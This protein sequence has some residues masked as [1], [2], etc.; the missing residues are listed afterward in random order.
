MPWRRVQ[1]ME[2]R[3]QFVMAAR[4][5]HFG[6]SQLC[7]EYGISRKTAYKWLGRYDGEHL[8]TLQDRSRAP[9]TCPHAMPEDV[10]AALVGARKA[11]R[12][13][14]PRKI[15]AYL[16]E[17]SDL[18]DRLP[19]ASTAGD[20]L[21][22]LGLVEPR[23]RRS[24]YPH[25][26][27]SPLEA[28]EPNDV[29]CVDFKGEFKTRD[30][31]WCYPLTVTDG[32]S[33]LLLM[34]DALPSTAHNGA[35]AAFQHLFAEVG[36]PL[37]IRSDNGCP[38]CSSA[39]NG[40]SRLSVWWTKLGIAHQR[41]RPASPHEN[42][43]HE[44]MHRTLKAETT[45]PPAQDARAQ[46]RRFDDFRYEFNEI[47][48]H[49]AIGMKPPITLWTPS[50]RSLPERLP[51]PDYDGHMLVRTVRH[52]GEMKFAG[53]MVFVSEVLVGEKVAL[54]EVDDGIWHLRFYNTLLARLDRRTMRL[55]PI[56]PKIT[57][58]KS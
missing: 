45:R 38:F 37:A 14:G 40:L 20:L 12:F 47:R 52:S 8:A 4:G 36:L 18:V 23:R 9:H 54:E 19:A 21:K 58:S 46:Q 42:G 11:H 13:W 24:R 34:C 2:E 22:R 35:Q 57:K 28:K 43:Q 41:I 31:V 48:P 56:I 53:S 55:V 51:G 25:P 17:R 3:V 50:P 44:R 49:E 29:W 6:V 27:S 16:A 15:L 26:G 1:P 7:R 33:R 32:H 5:G 10:R 30:G 39:I